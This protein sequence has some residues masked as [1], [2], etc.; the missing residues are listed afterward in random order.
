[1]K[2]HLYPLLFFIISPIVFNAQLVFNSGAISTSMA[3]LNTTSA[4]VWS[5]NNNIGQLANLEFSTVSAGVFQPFLISDLSTSSIA[6]GILSKNG[7]FGISYS[8]YGNEFLQFHSTGIGYSMSLNEQLS[9]GVKINYHYIN[10]GNVYLNKS[11]VSA[12]IG[13]AAQLNKELKIGVQIINPTMAELD[14][15]DNERIPT[16]MQIAVGYDLSKEVSA[17]FAVNKDIIYPASF[18]AAL[19]Y[20]PNTSIQFRGGI[21]TNPSLASFGIG[22]NFKKFQIDIAAQYHQILGFSPE[23]SLTYSFKN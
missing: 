22:T 11:T 13:I 23:I 10:A 20:K 21:G 12:D 7:G 8:N 2:K 9:G 17:H 18:L 1:M 19:E 6:V 16:I 5:V 3:G 14:D 4:N 15:F